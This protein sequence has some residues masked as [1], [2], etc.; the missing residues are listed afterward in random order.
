MKE[1]EKRFC[2]TCECIF[3]GNLKTLLL[4]KTFEFHSTPITIIGIS[5][6]RET[7]RLVPD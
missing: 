6:G 4:A 7:I 1:K 5:H 3:R 2:T